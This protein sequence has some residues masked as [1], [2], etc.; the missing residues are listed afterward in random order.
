MHARK[1]VVLPFLGFANI[2][3]FNVFE[4]SVCGHISSLINFDAFYF[5]TLPMWLNFVALC[6][7]PFFAVSQ[8]FFFVLFYLEFSLFTETKIRRDFLLALCFIIYHKC[9]FILRKLNKKN[10]STKLTKIEL[11][12]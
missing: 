12:A 6:R 9:I 7:L 4:C 11:R 1:T 3:Q 2:V 10:M 8:F 5:L